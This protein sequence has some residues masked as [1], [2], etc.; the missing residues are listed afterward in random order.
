MRRFLITSTLLLPILA[1]FHSNALGAEEITEPYAKDTNIIDNN[2]KVGSL[3]EELFFEENE[4]VTGT[5]KR[6]IK[7]S[8]APSDVTIITNE[9][10]MQS[11]ATNLGEVFRR[12]AVWMSQQLHRLKRKSPHAASWLLYLTAIECRCSSTG[13]SSIWT[14]LA[15]QFG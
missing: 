4:V 7:L 13:A 3:E 11:G 8:E 14:L 5:A 6:A 9:D 12:V 1:V 10:I 15:R 2:I